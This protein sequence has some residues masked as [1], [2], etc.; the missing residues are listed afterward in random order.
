MFERLR[1]AP[2][3]LHACEGPD[4]RQERLG[5]ASEPVGRWARGAGVEE[6]RVGQTRLGP[7]GLPGELILDAHADRDLADELSDLVV[8]VLGQT[9]EIVTANYALDEQIR[10]P[11]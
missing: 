7:K 8:L 5:I 6:G 9:L 4:T 2:I 11:G 3:L 1:D 10:P